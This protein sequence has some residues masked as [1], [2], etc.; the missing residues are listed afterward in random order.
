[1]NKKQPSSCKKAKFQDHFINGDII[2]KLSQR[3]D[4][5]LKHLGKLAYVLRQVA[6]YEIKIEPRLEE[7]ILESIGKSLVGL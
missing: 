4:K 1:M 3:L 7:K 5:R 2:C 6:A